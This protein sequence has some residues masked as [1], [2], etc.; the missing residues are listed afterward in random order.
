MNISTHTVGKVVR[1]SA[2]AKYLEGGKT[3]NYIDQYI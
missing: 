1:K 3:K 2:V